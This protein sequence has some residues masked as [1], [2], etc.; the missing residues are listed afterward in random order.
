MTV[1]K[2]TSGLHSVVEL[3]NESAYK[4]CDL[5]SALD[6]KKGGNDVVKLNKAGTRY[7][8]CGTLGHCDQGMKVKITTVAAGSNATSSPADAGSSSGASTTSASSAAFANFNS[9]TSFFAMAIL[10]AIIM[11]FAF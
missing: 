7:F 9:F 2:Y 6:S 11:V 10:S 1:F 8:A 4:N 5:G 3:P